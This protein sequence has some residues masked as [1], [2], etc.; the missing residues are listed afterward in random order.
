MK[1]LAAIPVSQRSPLGRFERRFLVGI[2]VLASCL[3]SY[4]GEAPRVS[5]AVENLVNI[6]TITSAQLGGAKAHI[7]F[8]YLKPHANGDLIANYS[9][10]QTQS[11]LQFGRQSISTDGGQTWS[12]RATQVS[13]DGVQASLVRPAGQM[14]RGFSVSRQNA[15]GFTTFSNSRYN[16]SD[17]GLTWDNGFED[18]FYDTGA[19]TYSF[20]YGNFGDVVESNGTLLMPLYGTRL[21]STRNESVLFESSDDGKHW[22]RRSTIA[23]YTSSVDLGQMGTEGPSETALLR[24]NTGNLLAVY[25]TGQPFPTSSSVAQTPSLFWSQSSDAGSTWTAP[26]SLGVAGGFPLLRQLE[27]GTVAL[28]TGRYGAKMMFADSTGKRWTTPNVIYNGPGS[29]HTELRRANDGRYVYVY[30]QSGFYPPSYNAAPPNAYVYDNDQSANL[31]AATLSIQT[32][33]AND[34]FNWLAEYHGD[35]AP[36]QASPSWTALTTGAVSSRYLA[37][38]GQDYVRISSGLSGVNNSLSYSLAGA[39]GSPWESIDFRT[40]VVLELRA[41]ATSST[42]EGSASVY[43]GDGLHGGIHFELDLDSVNLEGEADAAG[44]V[45]RSASN[46]PGFSSR[47]WHDY[48]LVIRPSS[49]AGGAIVGQLF[50]DGDFTQPILTQALSSSLVDEIRFGDLAGENLRLA[51]LAPT[52]LAGDY[53]NDGTVDGADYTFWRDHSAGPLLNDATP[54]SVS[55][56]DYELWRSRFGTTLPTASFATT[57]SVPEPST[58]S[59]WLTLLGLMGIFRCPRERWW[60]S[61]NPSWVLLNVLLVAGALNCSAAPPR[62]DELDAATQQRIR[63]LCAPPALA[64]RRGPYS[65]PMYYLMHQGYAYEGGWDEDPQARCYDQLKGTRGKHWGDWQLDRN[66]PDWQE[67][68]VRNWAELGLN[69]THLNVYPPDGQLVVDPQWAQALEDFLELSQRYGLAVGVR[70]D[71]IDE[72]KLWTVHPHNLQSQRTAYLA[73]VTQV[74]RLLK[75]RTAYY[76]LGDELTLKQPNSDLPE[77]AWTPPMYL[78]YFTQVSDAIK[79]QDPQAKVSMFAASSGEWFNVKWLLEHGYGEVGDALAINHFDYHTVRSFFADRDRL[80][81]NL[82]LLA[83][84]VGYVS[85]GAVNERYPEGDRYEPLPT[86]EAQAARIAQTMF[87]WWDL[88]AGA[89]PYYLSLRNWQLEGRL[90]PRWFGFLGFEDFVVT[91]DVL[92]VRRYP[93]WYAYQ[94]IT[95]TFYNRAELRQPEFNIEADAKLSTLRSFERPLDDGSELLL[96]LWN[97]GPPVRTK[98]TLATDEYRY[99]V[100][101]SLKDYRSWKSLPSEIVSSQTTLSLDVTDEPQIIRLVRLDDP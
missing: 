92:S 33:P 52:G 65:T 82:S 50:L 58:F 25:R 16:S 83:S 45:E 42:T 51:A 100:Q 12:L 13:G 77:Q 46:L 80:A 11:G 59:G 36:T 38:L 96:M 31:K 61:I 35:V 90:Y 53:N 95:H 70:L 99:P 75:G 22:T 15:A 57:T 43:L 68:M 62:F 30:D 98:L 21:G 64:E 81:P 29:G 67:A 37:E 74:A 54:E 71:A 28:T 41:R 97:E 72:T 56:A 10:G 49:S 20:L 9:V 76:V 24:L 5:V 91:K 55:Q 63:Q 47:V 89:A 14:S 78:A 23:S 73:W 19:V 60:K 18:A 40:G 85:N 79:R 84:G 26:K 101:V 44:Q 48:R 6:D 2:I 3:C 7:N 69:S 39:A 86:E 93:A 17:G 1:V 34:A 94:T 32:L 87:T 66:R 27:D 8:P 4:A 88:G